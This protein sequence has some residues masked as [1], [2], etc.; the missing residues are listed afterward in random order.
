MVDLKVDHPQCFGRTEGWW[1]DCQGISCE[2]HKVIFLV[3]LL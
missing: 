2:N 3:N 1:V